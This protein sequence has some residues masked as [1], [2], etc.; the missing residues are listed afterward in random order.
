MTLSFKGKRKSK[1]VYI[2]KMSRK[3]SKRRNKYS[4]KKRVTRKQR[5]MRGGDRNQRQLLGLARDL[6][7]FMFEINKNNFYK[8]SRYLNF[9]S[10]P[11]I[12][13]S[14]FISEKDI[15]IV[16]SDFDPIRGTALQD[17]LQ[18]HY[19]YPD[20]D[21]PPWQKF[22][23]KLCEVPPNFFANNVKPQGHL[24]NV[25]Q[26]SAN[27]NPNFPRDPTN[28]NIVEISF[29][30]L[31]YANHEDKAVNNNGIEIPTGKYKFA[32]MTKN[33]NIRY[34]DDTGTDNPYY[35]FPSI[36]LYFY[37]KG[38]ITFEEL[39]EYL[40]NEIPHSFLFNP[41][42]RETIMGAGD[43][44]VDANGYIVELTGYSGHTKPLPSNVVY[45]A[46][47]FKKLGY[48]LEFVRTETIKL[49]T[50]NTNRNDNNDR[51][52]GTY[53]NMIYRRPKTV[54]EDEDDVAASQAM[55]EEEEVI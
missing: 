52:I 6:Q 48:P 30:I 16:G 4:N 31:D 53:Y 41:R 7:N 46:N 11:T 3:T 50:G 34:V 5:V 25:K 10:N 40:G 49:Q 39:K 26:T 15:D 54:D 33:E 43:F 22:I 36:I 51:L 47:K 24:Q 12:K 19:D 18:W 32:L 27:F 14:E 38:I 9:D 44:T 13:V 29:N 17:V 37:N 1:K 42:K 55:E 23:G 35:H 45:S 20:N 28:A 8:R 2:K 21:N